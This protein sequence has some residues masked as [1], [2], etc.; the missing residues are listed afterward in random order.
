MLKYFS[1]HWCI[2]L[3]LELIYKL[4]FL[5]CLGDRKYGVRT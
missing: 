4:C 1:T 5:K 2:V 3:G